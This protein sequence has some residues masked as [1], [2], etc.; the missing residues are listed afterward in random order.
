[1]S[2]KPEFCIGESSDLTATP[3]GGTV[4]YTFVW[5]NGLTDGN[6]HTVSPTTTTTYK[7]T[8]TDNTGCL[9]DTTT[10]ITVNNLPTVD[11]GSPQAICVGESVTL[12]GSGATA[13]TWDNGVTDGVAFTPTNSSTYTVTGSD[14]GACSGTDQ[15]VIVVNPLPTV[16][17][18]DD[19]TIC[20]GESVTLSG[21]GATTYSWDNNVTNGIAFVPIETKTYTVVGTDANSCQNEVAVTITVANC[22]CTD[23]LALNYD[24]NASLSDNSCIYQQPTLEWPNVFTPNNDHINDEYMYSKSGLIEID[25]WIFNRWGNIMYQTTELDKYWD[26]KVGGNNASDGVYFVKYRAKGINGEEFEGHTFFHL[27]R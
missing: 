20:A 23:P 19:Q 1:M 10:T 21:S 15:V 14:G 9:G 27:A 2:I 18:G 3:S 12:S 11:A 24:S 4:P 22:G 25:Y 8:V 13:Y 7:V 16:F 5:D 26:G 17:A 6:A